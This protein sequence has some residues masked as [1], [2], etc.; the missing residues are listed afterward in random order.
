LFLSGKYIPHWAFYSSNKDTTAFLF[1]NFM[2]TSFGLSIILVRDSCYVTHFET[3]R[4]AR[5]NYRYHPDSPY[6][7]SANIRG[8][9]HVILDRYPLPGSQPP[10]YGFVEFVSDDFYHKS[11][12][13]DSKKR[14]EYKGYFKA[15]TNKL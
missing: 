8:R 9:A 6:V 12:N 14:V 13:G 7:S 3:V 10:V 11:V 2:P 15:S 1:N 4:G 5:D